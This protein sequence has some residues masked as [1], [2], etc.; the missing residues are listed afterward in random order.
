MNFIHD[1]FLLSTKT[2]RELYHAYAEPMPIIDYHC[3][4][5]PEAVAEDR[6]FSNIAQLW[7]SG[8]H[9]KWRLMRSCGID[10][11]YITGEAEDRE[12]FAAW[13]KT[14]ERAVGNPI[15]HW[16]MLELTRYFHCEDV[17]TSGNWEEIWT[18]CNRVI[19]EEGL[20]A[21]KI[22]E[23]SRVR[24][25]CTT[26]N[27]EDDLRF[28]RAIREDKNFSIAVLPAFRPDRALKIEAE[29]FPSYIK[30]LEEKF[31]KPVA[32]YDDLLGALEASMDRFQQMGCRTADH[33]LEYIPFLP[34]DA[35]QAERVFRSALDGEKLG[36]ADAER[37]KT[38]LLLD[39]GE[40]YAKRGWVMQLH[41]GARRNNN[42]RM[43]RRMGP[44]TGYDCIAG[45]KTGEK[46]P[47]FLDCLEQRDALPKTIVYSLDPTDNVM[48]DTVCGCFHQPGCRGKVQHG[49]A[50]WFSDH[51]KGMREH[52]ED[53]AAGGVLGNFVGM[54][55]DS[56]S[57]LSYT[58]HE[59]FRRV[60][61]GLLGEW[62]E[63]GCCPMDTVFLGKLVQDISY[64]NTR[65]YF[66]LNE[67]LEG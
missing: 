38:R 14:L 39:L 21:R 61:C 47:A 8:D 28:H 53:L 10:E 20:S 60:L 52:L 67:I 66:Q 44:D 48:I 51:L 1:D 13:A 32:S 11:R 18:H 22:M 54:L 6:R 45:R 62:A 15:Y 9:Y 7:L 5:E 17:L 23:A 63:A 26:D 50:W 3:H 30:L 29:D 27:P 35:E 16:S 57:F 41:Y 12:K 55:T 37:Y 58:R 49:S 43:F 65:E 19:A 59:Y 64:Y 24:A 34:A 36:E 56:R 42:I 46:L 4:L 31:A 2:A 33:G 40:S 25:V